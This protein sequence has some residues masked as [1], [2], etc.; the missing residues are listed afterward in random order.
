MMYCRKC[1]YQLDSLSESRCPECGQ[2]FDP[3]DPSTYFEL[4]RYVVDSLRKMRRAR[5][6]AFSLLA[7]S[8]VLL[9]AF[10]AVSALSAFSGSSRP[11]P[12]GFVLA[13]HLVVSLEALLIAVILTLFYMFRASHHLGIAFAVGHLLIALFL[14]PLFLLGL[15]TTPLLVETEVHRR[16][17]ADAAA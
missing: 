17:V 15:I 5:K 4:N 8:F 2:S 10:A 13:A 1:R 14:L 3:A 6:W 7:L 11:T 12:L 16:A 9:A